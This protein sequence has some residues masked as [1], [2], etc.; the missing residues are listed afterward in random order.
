[1][2]RYSTGLLCRSRRPPCGQR[3]GAAPS[4]F[5]L[6]SPAPLPRHWHRPS[7]CPIFDWI[8]KRNPICDWIWKRKHAFGTPGLEVQD[9][10]VVPRR[11]RPPY[12]EGPAGAIDKSLTVFICKID[13]LP[14]A[15]SERIHRGPVKRRMGLRNGPKTTPASKPHHRPPPSSCSRSADLGLRRARQAARGAHVHVRH[16][17]PEQE[18]GLEHP[19][20]RAV[21]LVRIGV[22]C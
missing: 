14:D 7:G 19:R 12:S 10:A 8:W 2:P 22:L 5:A 6:P 13:N 17:R 3:K 21:G 9:E 15:T 11:G 4:H 20:R 18:R 16:P 1:M